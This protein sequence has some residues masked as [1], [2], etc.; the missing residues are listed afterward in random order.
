MLQDWN[1]DWTDE[2]FIESGK[3]KFTRKPGGSLIDSGSYEYKETEEEEI[4]EDT[5]YGK[6]ITKRKITREYKS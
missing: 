3:Y 1:K 6:K 4:V 2:E 5:K